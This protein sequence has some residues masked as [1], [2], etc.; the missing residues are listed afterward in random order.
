MSATGS[1]A[2]GNARPSP[3]MRARALQGLVREHADAADRERHLP[4]AV[5]RAFAAAGL[6]R[7]GA[8]AA[9]GGE[10][11]DPMTQIDTI[12]TIAE[13]DGSAGWNLMIGVETFGLIAP[14]LGRC[15]ELIADPEVVMCSSTA[16]VGRADAV[17]GGYRING[18]WQFVSGC[19]NSDVFGA[20]VRLYRDGAPVPDRGNVYAMIERG[21]FEILDTWHVS[22]LRGS[23]SHDVRVADVFVPESRII[24]PIGGDNRL[25]TGSSGAA[26][27]GAARLAAASD[28]AGADAQREHALLRFPLGARLAY[29]KVAVALGIARA[30][31]TA[32]TGLA[33]GKVPRFSSTS[34]R[35]RGAAQRAVAV[36]AV[37]TNG[38]RALVHD[39]V[40]Q[41]WRAVCA[42]E[43]PS[44]R[45]LAL[46]QASCSQAV[47]DACSAV[48]LLADA[49]GTTANSIG[50][51][52]ERL[53][54]DVR[55]VRQ[56]ATVA[57]HHL[58]DA[59]RVLL[60]LPG[61]GLMLR[62]LEASD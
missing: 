47:A 30:A 3:V 57:S 61:Q 40:A 11:A 6:Y 10:A 8:P 32:F 23:G 59:G 27:P 37:R 17:S 1:G 43:R 9:C 60:G 12:E 21:D 22:G 18:Q 24:P 5:A 41:L 45:Q 44:A 29:N 33:T 14:G 52:L 19:H 28:A 4:A 58:D 15:P 50:H 46:F 42:G 48:D 56:H 38:A 53:S 62:G 13:A 39:E 55:V 51:P 2:A 54:R 34:L 16:A 36:A 49:A 25:S 20:T 7:I 26:I 31:L 35:E